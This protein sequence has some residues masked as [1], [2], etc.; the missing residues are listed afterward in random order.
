M[1]RRVR[2]IMIRRLVLLAL[3]VGAVVLACRPDWRRRAQRAAAP[4]VE[5]L[6]A[7][8][9]EIR[10][11]PP[12]PAAVRSLQEAARARPGAV[13]YRR[14]A[15]AASEAGFP[16]VAAEAYLKEAEIYRRQGD[17]NAAAVEELKAGRFR[18]E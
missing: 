14:L 5:R 17:P 7:R 10:P 2:A 13:T 8:L 3:L 9:P 15:D 6:P 18:A 11:D 4:L 12:L 1:S 16:R